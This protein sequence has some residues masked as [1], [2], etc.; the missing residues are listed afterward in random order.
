MKWRADEKCGRNAPVAV[1]SFIRGNSS[2]RYSTAAAS[3]S[4]KA[5]ASFVGRQMRGLKSLQ[6]RFHIEGDVRALYLR[7][8][9]G[10]R[11]ESP[12][13]FYTR[14]RT[15]SAIANTGFDSVLKLHTRHRQA[16]DKFG[17]HTGV[18]ESDRGSEASRR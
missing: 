18:I 14:S 4:S 1:R 10:T 5:S 13:V 3:S 8:V 15:A 9:G 6:T 17:R 11:P 7:F 16:L 12:S 2:R